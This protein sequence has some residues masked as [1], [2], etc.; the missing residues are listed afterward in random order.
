[1]GF[2]LIDARDDAVHDAR[3]D[4]TLIALAGQGKQVAS[5]WQSPQGLVVPRTYAGRPGFDAARKTFQEQGWP[6][7][8]RLSG[9]GIV[10]QGPGIVN[11]SLAYEIQGKPMD[12][13]NKA[14]L[15]L[16]AV[17]GDALRGWG[18]VSRPATVHGS[19]CDGRYNMAIGDGDDVRKVAGTAQVW[20]RS[21]HYRT[22][23]ERHC[24]LA[25][26]LIL[27][28][29]DTQE[30]TRAANAFEAATGGPL[31]YR[32]ERVASLHACAGATMAEHT[33]FVYALRERLALA[34]TRPMTPTHEQS[35]AG[36]W[37]LEIQ[38]RR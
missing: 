38:S 22:D 32:A 8:V 16:C 15:T 13:T 19:F 6:V 7:S 25:H 5:V 10:P 18:I 14:Y 12:H 11:V 31:R 20:R 2:I 23:C 26:A 35:I 1:M 24:V 3:F 27:A 29:V 28:A 37:N 33:D 30:V 9:G 21:P 36:A 4:E 34:L 17:I